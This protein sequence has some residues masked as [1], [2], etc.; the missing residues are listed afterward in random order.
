MNKWAVIIASA[1]AH[2][3]FREFIEFTYYFIFGSRGGLSRI[4]FRKQKNML[5]SFAP[6]IPAYSTSAYHLV[7]T[8]HGLRVFTICRRTFGYLP[9]TLELMKHDPLGLWRE[10]YNTPLCICRFNLNIFCWRCQTS[11]IA[12][13]RYLS[14]LARGDHDFPP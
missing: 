14:E 10:I 8:K 5:V 3:R 13:R 12:V 1:S 6:H 4:F 7:Q 11:I 2:P 9:Y